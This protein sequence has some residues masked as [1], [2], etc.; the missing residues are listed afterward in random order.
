MQD[1]HSHGE[2]VEV[3]PEVHQYNKRVR[4]THYIA[5]GDYRAKSVNCVV[6][7]SLNSLFLT[8]FDYGIVN[9]EVQ[10][11]HFRLNILFQV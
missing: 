9:R 4:M 11:L 8:Q 10:Y 2:Q 7:I 6:E 3:V 5:Y 1:T